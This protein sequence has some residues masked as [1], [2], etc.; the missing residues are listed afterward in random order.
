MYRSDLL[1]PDMSEVK[2]HALLTSHGVNLLIYS[3]SVASA[4]HTI[5]SFSDEFPLAAFL[6][7]HRESI[8]L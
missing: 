5:V 8:N 4:Q 1:L 7:S 2:E 6:L 3:I